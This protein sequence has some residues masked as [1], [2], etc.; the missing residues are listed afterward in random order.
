MPADSDPSVTP[1]I[2]RAVLSDS[3]RGTERVASSATHTLASSTAPPPL[4]APPPSPSPS[5]PA[6][7]NSSAL[8]VL[9]PLTNV[10]TECTVSLEVTLPAQN[11]T[12]AVSSSFNLTFVPLSDMSQVYLAALSYVDDTQPLQRYLVLC[13]LPAALLALAIQD[14]IPAS[15]APATLSAAI[16]GNATAISHLS[17]GSAMHTPGAFQIAPPGGGSIVSAVRTGDLPS[18]ILPLP[19]TTAGQRPWVFFNAHYT[20]TCSTNYKIVASYANISAN[21]T[22]APEGP[23]GT[24]LYIEASGTYT[25]NTS[26]TAISSSSSSSSGVGGMVEFPVIV[27]A[28]DNFQA[29]TYTVMLYTSEAVLA[30]Y[31][32]KSLST[33]LPSAAAPANTTAVAGV[34]SNRTGAGDVNV[35]QPPTLGGVLWPPL[36]CTY[37]ASGA[38]LCRECLVLSS[39][40]ARSGTSMAA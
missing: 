1:A 33:T 19:A 8:L 15:E 7:T 28:P 16:L 2:R 31:L 26:T 37:C 18:S 24:D 27:H 3:S 20:P 25:L 21:M 32:N 29:L 35:S 36:N 34:S 39:V 9:F 4:P 12:R 22:L 38:C 17:G 13:G 6:S 5:S 40:W 11:G 10:T 14:G 30:G 23:S